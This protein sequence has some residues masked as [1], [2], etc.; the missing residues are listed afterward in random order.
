VRDI[1]HVSGSHP[2]QGR[3]GWACGEV[4]V[5][6]VAMVAP[7]KLPD[8]ISTVGSFPE[9]EGNF[10]RLLE[11]YDSALGVVPFIGA[12][13]S[14]P[15]GFPSW[16]GFLIARAS[17]AGVRKEVHALIETGKYEEAADALLGALQEQAF[18]DAIA[19]AFGDHVLEDDTQLGLLS[20]VPR[21][22]LGP[23]IT[24]NFDHAIERAFE[25]SNQ[26]FERVVWGARVDLLAK[27]FTQNRRLLLKLHGDVDDRIDRILTL[28]D[29]N[30]H[31]GKGR[32]LPRLLREI[33]STRPVVFLGCSLST[34]RTIR[35]LAGIA[36]ASALASHYAILE[37]PTDEDRLRERARFL[38]EHRIRPIWYPYGRHDLIETLII[39]LLQQR[40]S[41]LT[42]EPISASQEIAPER[43]PLDQRSSLE[44]FAPGQCRKLPSERQ[45][46]AHSFDVAGHPG[47][48]LI[49]FYDDIRPAEILVM[50]GK[51]GSTVSGL[52]DCFAT[53]VSLGL[54]YGVPIQ[55]YIEEFAHTRFEPNGWSG[56]P[57]IGYSKSLFDYIFRWI[58]WRLFEQSDSQNHWG[59]PVDL[60][61]KLP[62]ECASVSHIFNVGGHG[63]VITVLLYPD[64][65]PG[66]IQA[67]FKKEGSTVS[68]L[69]DCWCSAMSIA[70]QHAVPLQALCDA[71]SHARFEP[72]GWTSNPDIGFAKSIADYFGRWLRLRFLPRTDPLATRVVPRPKRHLPTNS[73]AIQK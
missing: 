32:P 18:N 17:R 9:N 72:S 34:D 45:A 73:Q 50:M 48:L 14:V 4:A 8:P 56:N 57:H 54:Q 23:V 10:R 7:G 16:H 3:L 69:T 1:F 24:T 11:D 59:P 71:Y 28:R 31:Y 5:Y 22:A 30:R 27:A 26:P 25:V 40:S 58:R 65:R 68:G 38:S 12:G 60:G 47:K 49:S 43:S 13:L 61:N 53:A 46:I 35:V 64:G 52:L 2:G 33:F 15:L 29:Y 19:D 21:L 63:G 39:S 36:R 41:D 51:E 37:A 6:P 44:A 62:N 42:P 66:A 20:L 70:L 55:R 67:Q